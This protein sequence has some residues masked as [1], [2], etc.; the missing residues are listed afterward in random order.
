VKSLEHSRYS[1]FDMPFSFNFLAFL[2]GIISNFTIKFIGI[3]S[4]G[5]LLSFTYLLFI[6]RKSAISKVPVHILIAAIVWAVA[7]LLSDVINETDLADAIKGTTAPLLLL[8]TT[9]GLIAFFGR[10]SHRLASFLLGL[11]FGALADV[12]INP[13]GWFLQG[14]NPWK[15]G[16]GA[17]FSS[18]A[19]VVYSFIIEPKLRS[20]QRINLS[21]IFYLAVVLVLTVVDLGN[22]S[23]S[24]LIAPVFFVAYLLLRTGRLNRFIRFLKYIAKKSFVKPLAFVIIAFFVANIAITAVITNPLVL[25]FMPEGIQAK[26][27]E[28]SSNKWGIL[29]GGRSEIFGSAQAFL[30]KPL[31]GHGSWAKD[32]NGYYTSLLLDS[33]REAG[34]V[35]NSSSIDRKLQSGDVV[36]I[37][38]HSFLMGGFVWAGIAGGMF[39]IIVLS[40]VA[41]TFLENYQTLNYYLF[42]NVYGLFWSIFFSPFAYSTRFSTAIFMAVWITTIWTARRSRSVALAAS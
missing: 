28:Q 18:L 16:F 19:L 15:W 3:L 4:V 17:V 9:V 33:T 12:L 32:T 21:D 6:D 14:A 40:Y 30:D 2:V 20:R 10:S 8:L 41:R 5:E 38:Y 23:R 7:Q 35:V 37:P 22:E 25:S 13:K 36:L 29:L 34:Q 26:T 42:S 11:P 1:I 31:L 27:L 39:W 24:A